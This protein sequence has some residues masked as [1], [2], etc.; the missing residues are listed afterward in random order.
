M[1]TIMPNNPLAKLWS[2]HLDAAF[3][4][5]CRARD[6]DGIDLIMLDADIAGCVS[7]FLERKHSLDPRRIVILEDAL[8]DVRH[9]IPHLSPSAAAYYQ[10]LEQ[11]ANLLLTSIDNTKR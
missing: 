1:K 5:D 10:R 2:D 6:I 11:L 9:I 3:P 7:T 8:Q 4:P